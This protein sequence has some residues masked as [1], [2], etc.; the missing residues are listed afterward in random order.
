MLINLT[1]STTSG[2]LLFSV[3]GT[4]GTNIVISCVNQNNSA[5]WTSSN[6]FTG[7]FA[8]GDVIV[9]S[10]NTGSAVLLNT[11]PGYVVASIALL[12]RLA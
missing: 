5:I 7:Y 11:N 10:F 9:A 2:L 4:Y 8:A 1:A 12:Q 3:S 6:H